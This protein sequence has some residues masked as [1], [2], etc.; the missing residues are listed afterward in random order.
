MADNDDYKI[1]AVIKVLRTLKQFSA[2]EKELTL[3]QLSNRTGINKSNMLRILVSLESE[4]FVKFD[5]ELKKYRLG[6]TMYNLG[7]TAFGF[8]DIK[9]ICYPILRKASKDL[10][11][12]IHLAVELDGQVLV[13]DRIWPNNHEDIAGLV[14]KIG[15]TV[16]LHCT[17]VGKVIAAYVEPKKLDRLIRDCDFKKYSEKTITSKETFLRCVEEVR[18][19]GYAINDC[20]H[21][22]Y[23]RCLTRP[24]FD[25]S[26][27]FIA[28][29]SLSGL[30][31]IMDDERM[32]DFQIA[33]KEIAKSLCKEFGA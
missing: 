2:E 16:P 5:E 22:N 8:L 12:L 21:E 9:K 6:I 26:G 28:A 24:I 3:T 14:S 19:N 18:R 4:G 20:E 15:G 10:Q 25:S 17:G 33:S 30:S 13:I 32:K 7:N 27:K 1:A 29:F 31:E 11:L 23:L